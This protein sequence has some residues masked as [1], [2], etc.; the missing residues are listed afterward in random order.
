MPPSR[1]NA[2]RCRLP[3]TLPAMKN[4]SVIEHAAGAAADGVER[5]GT[6]AVGELHADA[7]HERADQQRRPER[8]DRAAEAR[9]QRGDR[10]D[11]GGRNGDQQ[12]AAEQT[13]GLAA[14]DQ[15]PPRRGEAELGL[16]EH[17]AE[18]KAEPRSARPRPAGRRSAPA[19]PAPRSASTDGDQERPVEARRRAPR[20]AVRSQQCSWLV[21]LRLVLRGGSGAE[22]ERLLHVVPAG[23]RRR[24][25]AA[26]VGGPF[27]HRAVVEPHVR[28]ARAS[29]TAR[30][31]RSPP[32]GRCCNR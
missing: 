15:P 19:R 27:D 1:R 32:S 25:R 5:A 20:T 9:H 16:E 21:S 8:R 13:V 7:E 22:A 29:P 3:I 28:P 12:Q 14:H 23:A 26:R 30:T 11:R 2:G 31:S 4:A 18:R 10:H 24:N 17:H 6:A